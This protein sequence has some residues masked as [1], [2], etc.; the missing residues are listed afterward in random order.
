[1]NP[2]THALSGWCLAEAFPR[3]T[4]RDRAIITIAAIAPDVDG[5]GAIA[6]IATRNTNHPLL[7]WT[8]YHHVLAHNLAFAIAMTIAAFAFTRSKLTAILAFIAVHLHLAGDLIGSRGPDGYQWPIPYL[9]PFREQP[10]LTWSGQWM[11]NAWPNIVLTIA[12]LAC[13]FVLAWRRG[14]S[15]VGLFSRKADAA[16]VATL[17]ARI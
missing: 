4:H 8:D 10:Q 7:W 3:F 14:Y 15:I 9:Y 1:M 12:M 16:F 5:L 13:V 11:L 6:E 17:R 2:I